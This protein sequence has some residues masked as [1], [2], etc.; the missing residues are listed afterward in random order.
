MAVRAVS[1]LELVCLP[2]ALH[3]LCI[4]LSPQWVEYVSCDHLSGRNVHHVITSVG[5]ICVM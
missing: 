3:N 5:G 1:V 4:T 2:M